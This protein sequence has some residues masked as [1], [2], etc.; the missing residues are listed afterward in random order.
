MA[1][2]EIRI[3]RQGIHNIRRVEN[4]LQPRNHSLRDKHVRD[5]Q[6]AIR[7]TVLGAELNEVPL[8]VCNHMPAGLT[9][10]SD[11]A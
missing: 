2:E 3:D 4:S 5:A 1:A 6:V 10:S 9:N 7:P 8:S 11:D